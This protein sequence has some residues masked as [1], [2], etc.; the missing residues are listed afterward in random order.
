MGWY[1][2]YNHLRQSLYLA[3]PIYHKYVR[4]RLDTLFYTSIFPRD[5]IFNYGKIIAVKERSGKNV[6]GGLPEY[7][8]WFYVT[9]YAGML[10]ISDT[11]TYSYDLNAR[12]YGV[13]Q[14]E[15][16]G[17][18]IKMHNFSIQHLNMNLKLERKK[19]TSM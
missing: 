11:N 17:Y 8:D 12:C 19:C 6:P 10:A 2:Q 3:G 5:L 7:K 14:E 16:V 13:C 1:A 18:H 9:D 4:A 15:Q